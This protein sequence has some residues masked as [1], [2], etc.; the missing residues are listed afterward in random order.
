[1]HQIATG[2]PNTLRVGIVELPESKLADANGRI[3]RIYLG[4]QGYMDVGIKDAAVL[5]ADIDDCMTF[6]A[7]D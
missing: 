6:L 5:A 3:L 2:D 7:H 4:D 1:M